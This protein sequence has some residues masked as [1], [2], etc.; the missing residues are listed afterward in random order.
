M[1]HRGPIR[2]DLEEKQY[3][4]CTC[5]HSQTHPFC[6]GA[7]KS[8]GGRPCVHRCEQAGPA[9]VCGC[10]KSANFPW[11]DGSHRPAGS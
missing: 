3:A 5:G 4:F 1:A 9:V 6:D 10:G 8:S 2:L 7:H 11:C